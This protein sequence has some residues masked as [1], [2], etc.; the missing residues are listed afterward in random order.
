MTRLI[1]LTYIIGLGE[2]KVE[3]KLPDE[4]NDPHSSPPHPVLLLLFLLLLL[5]LFFIR[6]SL[7]FDQI[8]RDG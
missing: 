7:L 8:I 4:F 3:M 6:F 2:R 1:A 5:Q